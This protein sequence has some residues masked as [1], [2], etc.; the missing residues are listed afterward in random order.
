MD[1]L[2]ELYYLA[3]VQKIIMQMQASINCRILN[4]SEGGWYTMQP[5][6]KDVFRDAIS[7][8]RQLGVW[9]RLNIA[10]KEALV[11]KY[12]LEHYNKN[13]SQQKAP[14]MAGY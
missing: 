6:L 8:A 2:L 10:Q 4:I 12:L 7:K 14:A 5:L 1:F 3:A 9:E 13:R 11:S